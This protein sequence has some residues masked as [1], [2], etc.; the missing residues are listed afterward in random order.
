MTDSNQGD[1]LME[2]PIDATEHLAYGRNFNLNT[3][4]LEDPLVKGLKTLEDL[5][6]SLQLLGNLADN[7]LAKMMAEHE[8]L[9]S[10]V[11]TAI[12]CVVTKRHAQAF[13]ARDDAQY[14][15][16]SSRVSA[17]D[18]FIEISTE[19]Q[20]LSITQRGKQD[21]KAQYDATFKIENIMDL[22]DKGWGLDQTST[23]TA[24][25]PKQVIIGFVGIPNRGKTFLMNKIAGANLASGFAHSTQGISIKTSQH[26][27]KKLIFLDTKGVKGP[28]TIAHHKRSLRKSL[29]AKRPNEFPNASLCVKAD[30]KLLSQKAAEE[31]K[32]AEIINDNKSK[33]AKL[34]HEEKRMAEIIRAEETLKSSP[35]DEMAK[36]TV[37]Q[38]TLGL[39][40]EFMNDNQLAENLIQSFVVEW[41]SVIILVVGQLNYDDQKLISQISLVQKKNPLKQVYII[42]N[43][44]HLTSTKA[45]K[46]AIETDILNCFLVD[47]I[48]KSTDFWIYRE[49]YAPG[50]IHLVTARFDTNAGFHYNPPVINFLD[51]IVKEGTLEFK[52]VDLIEEFVSFATKRLG[53]YLEITNNFRPFLK[54]DHKTH[55]MFLTDVLNPPESNERI[56]IEFAL[57]RIFV[58][59][60]G[61]LEKFQKSNTFTPSYAVIKVPNAKGKDELF[62]IL[63]ASDVNVSGLCVEPKVMAKDKYMIT[64]KGIRTR[65]AKIKEEKEKS[66]AS[67]LL[68][69]VHFNADNLKYGDIDFSFEVNS[70]EELVMPDPKNI[71]YI[72]SQ[73]IAVIP[74]M[75]SNDIIDESDSDSDE[76][77]E[78]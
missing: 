47:A 45:V 23:F 28:V 52:Q 65:P 12:D 76:M 56:G 75:G 29:I 44:L 37:R 15:K 30:S 70:S 68:S 19:N 9:K 60:L 59:A 71:R 34:T 27:D 62:C 43:F 2:N 77:T 6:K 7:K 11:L 24:K 74:L 48:E 5:A 72:A 78:L 69:A 38:A 3:K 17:D 1:T 53:Y 41:A 40:N 22:K 18:K 58:D 21:T 35:N 14:K 31:V 50:V 66:E 55:H 4:L 25:E 26:V 39:N 73:G 16:I 64:V 57:K 20:N 54:Y 32:M 33:Q 61:A 42:H 63:S 51:K 49:R 13:K 46:D 10:E 36:E 67:K 8:E